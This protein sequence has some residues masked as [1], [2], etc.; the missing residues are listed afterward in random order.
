MRFSHVDFGLDHRL[1]AEGQ[2]GHG[3]LLFDAI[4]HA[5]ERAVVVAGEMHHG[6]AHGF[7]GDGSGID[8]NTTDYGA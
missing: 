5:I 7:G 1:D 8:T 4:V 6:F 3:D 2:V